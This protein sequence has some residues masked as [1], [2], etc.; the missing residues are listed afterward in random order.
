M[1]STIDPPRAVHPGQGR[2]ALHHIVLEP[3][4]ARANIKV[5]QREEPEEEADIEETAASCDMTC[6]LTSCG[7]TVALP[8]GES[9]QR[10]PTLKSTCHTLVLLHQR[11]TRQGRSVPGPFAL[12]QACGG[13]VRCLGA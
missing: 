12:S 8:T 5:K 11:A 2:N 9:L 7:H 10:A 6:A 1:R 3:I 4:K 13:P